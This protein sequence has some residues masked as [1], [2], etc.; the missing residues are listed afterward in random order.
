MKLAASLA[1][2]NLIADEDLK[3]DYIIPNALNSLVPV[4][5]ARAVAE[6]AIKTGVAK[7]KNVSIDQIE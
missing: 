7:N 3:P 2:A 4:A 1:I 5:V 6:S